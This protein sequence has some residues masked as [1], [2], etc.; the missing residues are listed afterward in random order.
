MPLVRG[1]HALVDTVRS[2]DGGDGGETSGDVLFASHLL[3]L[4]F[5]ILGVEGGV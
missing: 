3:A 4:V 2:V 5:K 1:V